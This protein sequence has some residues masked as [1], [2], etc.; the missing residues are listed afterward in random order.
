MVELPSKHILTKN[1]PGQTLLETDHCVRVECD[2]G[3]IMQVSINR[4][5]VTDKTMTLNN[6]DD[7]VLLRFSILFPNLVKNRES[8]PA[9]GS[10]LL[11][12][13]PA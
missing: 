11:N 13:P 4:Q 6:A 3:R 1:K 12:Q 9:R 8:G 7:Q 10:F 2:L 5:E